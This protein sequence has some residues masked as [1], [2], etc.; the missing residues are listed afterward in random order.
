MKRLLLVFSFVSFFNLRG[1]DAFGL[2]E[3]QGVEQLNNNSLQALILKDVIKNLET[4]ELSALLALVPVLQDYI[5]NSWKNKNLHKINSAGCPARWEI[6]Q[7]MASIGAGYPSDYYLQNYFNSI[8]LSADGKILAEVSKDKN[9]R[10]WFLS[11]DGHF[12]VKQ[13]LYVNTWPIISIALSGDGKTLAVG[14]GPRAKVWRLNEHGKYVDGRIVVFTHD[15]VTLAL[16]GDGKTL[17]AG[18]ANNVSQIY[19]LKEDGFYESSFSSILGPIVAI[20]D[21]GKKVALASLSGELDVLEL[22][23][24][25]WTVVHSL[26]GEW[27]SSVSM[28][29]DGSVILV[30]HINSGVVKVLRQEG[31]GYSE[32]SLPSGFRQRL[33]KISSN[34]KVVVSAASDFENKKSIA[35]WAIKKDVDFVQEP[36]FSEQD[37]NIV[38]VAISADGKTI[39]SDSYSGQVAAWEFVEEDCK[40][41]LPIAYAVSKDHL[42]AAEKLTLRDNIDFGNLHAG[43]KD[44]LRSKGVTAKRKR[45]G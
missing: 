39:V 26:V 20:S 44:H 34:G 11:E 40:L 14:Y 12:R 1:M 19:R 23:D 25:I 41:T 4:Y 15:V 28:S 35:V 10:I 13:R 8:A 2:E 36:V 3:V 43:I 37:D 7:R 17:A 32:S 38:S 6:K 33:S 27:P 31:G 9:V 24:N 29:G 5:L 21:D 30:N 42:T 45:R 16:S 22:Q 18:Y